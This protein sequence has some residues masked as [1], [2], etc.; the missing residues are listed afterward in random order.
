V[1][2]DNISAHHC[3]CSTLKIRP[4][5]KPSF[6]SSRAAPVRNRLLGTDLVPLLRCGGGG[7]QL[8]QIDG[9]NG[10]HIMLLGS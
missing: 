9:G 8:A 2:V 5:T 10:F 4:R 3:A 1:T 6:V 7:T